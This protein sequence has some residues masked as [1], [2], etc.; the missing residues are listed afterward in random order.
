MVPAWLSPKILFRNL[1]MEIYGPF[2]PTLFY[3]WRFELN[4]TL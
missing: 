1:L 4:Y 2:Y 3:V